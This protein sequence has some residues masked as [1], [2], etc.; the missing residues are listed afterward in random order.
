MEN[1]FSR[2][3][4]ASSFLQAVRQN[5]ISEISVIPFFIKYQLSFIIIY[6]GFV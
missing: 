6:K 4:I 2:I 5:P 1:L 3:E